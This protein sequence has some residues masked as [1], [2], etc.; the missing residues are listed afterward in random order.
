MEF[1]RFFQNHIFKWL[2][3]LLGLQKAVYF[4]KL[5]LLTVSAFLAGKSKTLAKS[6]HS[7]KQK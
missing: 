1:E 2:G 6:K 5:E 3:L 4:P 7:D